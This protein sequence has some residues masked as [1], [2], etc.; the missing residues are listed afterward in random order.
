MSSAAD[1]SVLQVLSQAELASIYAERMTL[2]AIAESG[3]VTPA[4]K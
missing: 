3:I 1:I 2:S 4:T